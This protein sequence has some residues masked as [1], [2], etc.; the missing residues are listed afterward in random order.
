MEIEGNLNGSVDLGK[1]V[2]L[3]GIK[4]HYTCPLCGSSYSRNGENTRLSYP[5]TNQPY[6]LWGYCPECNHDFVIGKILLN[7]T[8]TLVKE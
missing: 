7:I 1:R 8:L 3:P 2:A 6:E 4:I 5:S